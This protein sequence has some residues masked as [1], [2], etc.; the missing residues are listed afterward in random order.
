MENKEQGVAVN[1]L[2][3]VRANFDC[4]SLI[5]NIK[6]N[7][8][9]GNI[10]ALE[11]A[12]VLKRMAKVSEE[13]LKDDT[14]KKMAMTELEKYA[15]ELKGA[16]KSVNLYSASMSISPTYT[17]YDFSQCGHEVLDQLYKIQEH[18]KEMIKQIEE[19]VK[20][21]PSTENKTQL[22]FGIENTGREMV[23][24]KM[25]SL[26]WEDYGVIGNVQPPRKV[27]TIGIRFNKV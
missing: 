25:P 18:C 4:K 6:E 12:V 22:E 13:V 11:G 5:A 26:Q 9:G 7:I 27:Q 21:I 23:F 1:N 8:I 17:F 15:G 14:I 20:T 24:S 2:L 16:T 19:E 10:S 3:D